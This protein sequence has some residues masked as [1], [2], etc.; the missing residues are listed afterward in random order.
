VKVSRAAEE[1]A[2]DRM[3]REGQPYRSKRTEFVMSVVVGE[4]VGR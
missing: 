3:N 1:L 4:E 2:M